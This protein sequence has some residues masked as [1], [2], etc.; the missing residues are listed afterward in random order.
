MKL[1][2]NH[3][4][5]TFKPI[6]DEK[7]IRDM[8]LSQISDDYKSLHGMRPRGMYQDLSIE[9]LEKISKDLSDQIEREYEQEKKD[10]EQHN[11]ATKAAMTPKPFTVGDVAKISETEKST[12]KWNTRKTRWDAFK[13]KNKC[14]HCNGIKLVTPCKQCGGKGYIKEITHPDDVIDQQGDGYS[15]DSQR[16]FAHS[17]VTTTK[18]NDVAKANEL[19]AQGKYV[20]MILN[21]A[22]CK[23]T[24]AVLGQHQTIHSV[25]DNMEDAQKS[26]GEVYN[27]CDGVHII[28]PESI[29]AKEPVK[30]TTPD[31]DDV[32]FECIGRNQF[33]L[34]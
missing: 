33:K 18:E 29:K 15:N 11:A 4:G 25:N 14:P 17:Q 19:A 13:S 9:E 22:H 28:S 10:E 24:D 12:G 34:R 30:P 31:V 23:S 1:F 3:G 5:N 20:V 21:N 6:T 8:L 2:E 26:A 32:P 27:S 7:E 16:A